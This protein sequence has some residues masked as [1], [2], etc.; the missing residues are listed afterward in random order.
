M[1]AWFYPFFSLSPTIFRLNLILLKKVLMMSKPELNAIFT[2]AS[3]RPCHGTATYGIYYP[4]ED[5]KY[6]GALNGYYYN[7]CT[8]AEFD[9]IRDSII[10]I[11]N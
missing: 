2:D 10:F 11:Q 5:Y 6:S 7:N 8:D 1:V 9:A 4:S 3:Y